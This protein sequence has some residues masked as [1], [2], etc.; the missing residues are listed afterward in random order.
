METTQGIHRNSV[1]EVK[2]SYRPNFR[3]QER[4]ALRTSADSYEHFLKMDNWNFNTDRLNCLLMNPAMKLIAR[5][6]YSTKPY[7]IK[8]IYTTALLSGATR[9]I[10]GFY[11]I[12][13]M[14][15]VEDRD[16][17]RKMHVASKHIGVRLEDGLYYRTVGYYS[18][19]DNDEN[20]YTV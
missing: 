14:P 16:F 3:P 10:I 17:F 4:P 7:S 19:L 15:G 6:S 9:M 18:L 11:R 1:S 13:A 12:T 20:L 5:L 8:D 2:L